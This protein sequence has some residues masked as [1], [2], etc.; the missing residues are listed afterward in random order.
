MIPRTIPFALPFMGDSLALAAMRTRNV[1][2]DRLFYDVE[3]LT[4]DESTGMSILA[5][6]E[7]TILVVPP[8]GQGE[9]GRYDSIDAMAA[10]GNGNV[11]ALVIAG[12]GGSALGTAALSRNVANAIGSPVVGVVSGYGTADLMTEALGGL[13]WFGLGTRVRHLVGEMAPHAP[14]GA[15]D[16]GNGLHQQMVASPDVVATAKLL[17]DQR[18]PIGLVVGHSKGNLVLSAALSAALDRQSHAGAPLNT[19]IDVV[20]FSAAIPVPSAFKRVTRV[21]GE[22]D[23]FG[24][25]NSWSDI[26]IDREIPGAWHYTNTKMFSSLSVQPVIADLWSRRDAGGPVPEI[27]PKAA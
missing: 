1:A 7:G 11:A 24:R 6:R 10:A 3:A 22:I 8:S 27:T 21:M 15:A 19:D 4:D 14:N 12:I 25:M 18:F 17:T 2:L 5:D 16:L 26:V 13:C 20:M 23:W 9:I